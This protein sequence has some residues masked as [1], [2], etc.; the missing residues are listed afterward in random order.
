MPPSV[1]CASSGK[2]SY[3]ICHVLGSHFIGSLGAQRIGGR[4]RRSLILLIARGGRVGE[5][6]YVYCA[7][8]VVV[9]PLFKRIFNSSVKYGKH[10]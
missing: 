10:S 6:N 9:N 1:Q 8:F 2:P 4:R 7:A 3:I 5:I